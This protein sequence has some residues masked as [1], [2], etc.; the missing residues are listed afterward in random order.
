M[1]R[2]IT[3]AA[4]RTAL[5]YSLFAA[6]WILFSDRL[7]V[8]IVG[9]DSALVNRL[10]TLKGWV[11][12]AVTAG[13]L[14]LMVARVVVE[15]RRLERELRQRENLFEVMFSQSPLGNA[16]VGN[17]G[18]IVQANDR[19]CE[20]LGYSREDLLHAL[21]QDIVAPDDLEAVRR[22]RDILLEGFSPRNVA[23]RRLRRKDG[24][25]LWAHVNVTP[26]AN[27]NGYHFVVTVEDISAR[28]AAESA[29]QSSEEYY[30]RYFNQALIGMAVTNAERRWL[31]VNDRLCEMLGY[32]REEMLSQTWASMTHPD[33]LNANM[34]MFRRA[35]TGELDNYALEKRFI[36]SD[37]ET[38]Y[39]RLATQVLRRDDGQFD[40]M[41]TSIEDVTEQRLAESELRENEER[42]RRMVQDMPVLVDAIDEDFNVSFWNSMCEQVT[43]FTA[44]EIVGNPAALEMLYPDP[45]YRQSMIEE[46]TT[47]S[48]VYHDW[49][50]E[51]TCKDGSVRSIAWRKISQRAPVSGWASWGVGIDITARLTMEQALR[52]SEERYRTLVE[53]SPLPILVHRHGGTIVFMNGA[54]I[55]VLAGTTQG[56]FLGRSIFEFIDPEDHDL[57]RESNAAMRSGDL[58]L[59]PTT[60]ARFVQLEGETLDVEVT[61][62]LVEYMGDV[63]TQIIF[64]D[65]GE[66]KRSEEALHR[67]NARLT[68]LHEIDQAILSA[69]S[70]EEIAE[71]AL[72]HIKTLIPCNRVSLVAYQFDEGQLRVLAAQ[73]D[74]PSLM[75]AGFVAPL[76]HLPLSDVLWQGEPVAVDDLGALQS[77]S[78]V[79]E[80][81]YAEGVQSCISVPLLVHGKL[82]ASLN[83]GSESVGRLS[84]EEQ[85]IAKEVCNQLALAL[86]QANLMTQI[87]QHAAELEQRV[88]ERTKA[89]TA[90]NARLQDLDRLKS[91]FVSDVSHELRSPIT[92]LGMYL[93]LLSRA[94]PAKH[95]HYLDILDVQVDRLKSL[96]EGILDLSRLDLGKHKV[97]FT[98]VDLNAI[99]SQTVTAYQPQAEATGIQLESDLEVNMPYVWGERNQLAQIVANLLSNA[100][101]YTPEGRVMVKTRYEP[102]RGRVIFS[103]TDT[104]M[105]IQPH[106]LPHLF[107]RFYRG[108][109]PED[110]DVPGTG[111]GLGIVKEIVDLHSGQITVDSEPTKGSTFTVKLPSASSD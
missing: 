47:H 79:L 36:R 11:F 44:E 96:V 108:E 63:V 16:L 90:A 51:I 49:V 13:L 84:Q 46:W 97:E 5:T 78:P 42:F 92:N 20:M 26:I 40:R 68:A 98:P 67:L 43:G 39:A 111:L 15:Q 106:D 54:A 62:R 76:E 50:W 109:Q 70:A 14:Y 104:G 80:Q 22:E 32:S 24:S 64:Q 19:L 38:V 48:D 41:L 4:A 55:R 100:I 35:E 73:S 66:R 8:W 52:S 21:V 85:D 6:L 88:A 86:S 107:D 110:L 99:I 23:D 18:E 30:R 12:V 75:G 77:R 56:D 29:L 89:L 58:D 9:G 61:G 94:K 103:V 72:K 31:N 1:D 65:I 91:K 27:D 33:D 81:L 102:A 69:Q 93:H 60:Q 87:R 28:K 101:N 7:L 37:G 25:V 2:T 53:A 34:T 71:S 57:M 95:D 17:E 82:Y 10:Q 45:E 3:R 105:G 74:G 59:L 83:I